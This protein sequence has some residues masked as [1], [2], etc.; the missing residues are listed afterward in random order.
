MNPYP[1][2]GREAIGDAQAGWDMKTHCQ[3]TGLGKPTR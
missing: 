3:A 1:R 2:L